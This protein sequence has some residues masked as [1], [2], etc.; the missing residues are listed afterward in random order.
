MSRTTPGAS[1]SALRRHFH[2]L[3]FPVALALAAITTT[4]AGAQ[5]LPGMPKP[6]ATAP[7][8]PAD[9]FGRENPRGL[10]KAL[11]G[12]LSG[13]GPAVAADVLQMSGS[14]E[15][16]KA[17]R[18][19]LYLK[20]L[21]QALDKS[22]KL[23]DSWNVAA[24]PEGRHADGLP[25]GQEQIG[26]IQVEKIQIP[27][28][29]TRIV[30]ND[31]A[32]APSIWMVSHESLKAIH[33]ASSR[34]S[35]SLIDRLVPRALP[36]VF[37]ETI[38]GVPLTHFV[39]ALAAATALLLA[40]F[41]LVRVFVFLFTALFRISNES[42][43]GTVIRVLRPMMVTMLVGMALEPLLAYAGVSVVL[44]GMLAPIIRVA[45]VVAFTFILI[46]FADRI[47]YLAIERANEMGRSGS[48]SFLNLGR[49]AVKIT[50]FFS[51]LLVALNAIGVDLTA[52]LAALGIG[53]IA[54]ALGSQ[55]T[56]GDF[57]GSLSVVADRVVKI[58][59]VCRFGTIYG[60]VEDIGIRS[61]RIRTLDRTMLTV[62]NGM[63][64]SMEVENISD[65]DKFRF[66]HMIQLSQPG[67]SSQLG[68]C[69]ADLRRLVFAHENIDPSWGKIRLHSYVGGLPT[70]EF[71]TYFFAEDMITFAGIQEEV[72]LGIMEVVERHG[73]KIGVP[74]Q[75]MQITDL[76]ARPAEPE[77]SIIA[78][79]TGKV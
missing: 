12:A 44:R 17:A 59:D 66:Y 14:S 60:T 22:G 24:E 72:L 41:A 53:G 75:V 69:L 65:R 34:L 26:F 29:A 40:S 78:R 20:S 8:A 47:V 9:P 55:K 3:I 38:K 7:A 6:A 33:E 79:L 58:G 51:A 71:F 54:V 28:I 37:S 25:E 48:I 31:P 27:I 76:G 19:N 46:R 15:S 30:S 42:K 39:F 43:T 2:G 74:T 23:E 67:S 16:Q 36:E 56:I 35:L 64:S 61:T 77:K 68:D 4:A 63:F 62:P 10:V 73:M 21:H 52:G 1:K 70:V 11:L 18:L 57:V 32:V 13:N 45:M 5:S 49:R 50:L